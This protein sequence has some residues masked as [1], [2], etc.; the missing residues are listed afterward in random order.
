MIRNSKEQKNENAGILGV[1]RIAL[2]TLQP[3]HHRIASSHRIALRSDRR[4]GA[5]GLQL[6]SPA[7]RQSVSLDILLHVPVLVQ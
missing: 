2:R 4:H 6:P 1:T 3:E 5:I 7:N